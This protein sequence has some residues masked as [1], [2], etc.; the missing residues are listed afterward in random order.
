MDNQI[1]TLMLD[2]HSSSLKA[3]AYNFTK[4]SEDADDLYQDTVMKALN[5]FSKYKDGTNLKAW[6]FTIMRNTFINSYHKK[7]RKNNIITTKD[8]LSPDDL[9]IGC[10]KNTAEGNLASKD[11]YRMLAKLPKEYLDPFTRH[12]EG[13]KY[14]EIAD[15]LGLPLGTVKTRIH[16]ARK[17]LK[18]NLKPYAI[19]Q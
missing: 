2:Q 1:F 5:Y 13:Y 17:I 12:F 8:E 11:I 14:H 16:A 6:L 4:D 15:E 3:F 10:T 9:H 19:G 7:K 18:K